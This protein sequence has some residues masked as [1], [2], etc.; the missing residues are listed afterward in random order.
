MLLVGLL[1]LAC[2]KPAPV[3]SEAADRPLR[4]GGGQPRLRLLDQLDRAELRLSADN[5]SSRARPGGTY[6]LTGS[7]RAVPGGQG[8]LWESEAPIPLPTLQDILPPEGLEL[9]EGERRLVWD[10]RISSDPRLLDRWSIHE[11]RLR[12]TS[13]VEPSR[14]PAAMQLRLQPE[15]EREAAWNLARAALPLRE[16]ARRS[17]SL[18]ERTHPCLY[19]PAPSQASFA[20]ALPAEGGELRLEL[21]LADPLGRGEGQAA[22][23]ILLDGQELGRFEARAGEDWQAVRLNL[24]PGAAT[25]RQ[26][27]LES[28]P[29]GAPDSDYLCLGDPHIRL[30][31]AR[32]DPVRVVLIGV[33]TLRV[34]HLGAN[35]YPR[36]TSPFLDELATRAVRLDRAWAPAPRTRPSFRTSLTGRWPLRARS[37]P[38]IGRV[39]A[40]AGMQTAGIV[41]NVHLAPRLGFAD[42]YQLWS[43]D[44]GARADRQVDRALS[45]L[46]EHRDEDS[47]LFLHLM[48]PH[49]FYLA[50][51][52][53][54]DRFTGGTE[55]GSVP[56]RFNRWSIRELEE[57]GRLGPAQKA[58]I[59]GRYDGEIA[60]TDAQLGRLWE[61]IKGLPGRTLLVLHSDHG[62]ELWEH[63]AFEHNHSLYEELNHALLWFHGPGL[64]PRRIDSPASLA[65]IA[66][67]LYEA[68]G[69]QGPDVD[70]LSL[71]PLLTG[72]DPEQAAR[73]DRRPLHLGYLMFERERF[74][75]VGR[76][77]GGALHKYILQTLSGEEELYDLDRDPGERQDLAPQAGQ[78][79]DDW[80]A[81]LEE[82][83]GWP[84]GPGWRLQLSG[85][86]P[87]FELVFSA[88]LRAAGPIDPEAGLGRRAN[89]EWGEQPAWWPEDVARVE[90]LDE[91]RR[92]RVQPGA[93]G[94]GRLYLL[95][96][97]GEA[98]LRIGGREERLGV[99][100]LRLPEGALEVHPGRILVPL[101]HEG[102]AHAPA[103]AAQM[104]ALR[105]L[106]YVE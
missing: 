70:G 52:P 58:F 75:V 81:L 36:P 72:A 16:F 65:D 87:A 99:E 98:I 5:L 9:W 7:W 61:G 90:L 83:T 3:R 39:L 106:G 53:W 31:A 85:R 56:D 24:P 38:G 77:A 40:E 34:D 100:G 44:N 63:G 95:G 35:G 51:E 47:F 101:E 2:S 105:S 23:R 94:E 73:L 82:A 92:V 66:P 8:R 91:G 17:L 26:L 69:I 74:A 102:E 20:L 80:A 25:T 71:W 18:G 59:T 88:P 104:E 27:V 19:L 14:R 49:T 68:L 6:E 32:P 67:T 46:R 79:L 37:T 15:A 55:R 12:R 84:A 89:L 22:L 54:R 41:A 97:R 4:I 45:W 96:A 13:P 29:L 11:G 50:P 42:G 10:T 21:G 62:E 33:D 43:Y 1:L 64:A 60:F 28:D 76:R 78:E 30:P 57:Q 93:L 86:L 48:D 103:E